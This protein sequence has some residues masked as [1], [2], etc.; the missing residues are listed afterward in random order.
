MHTDFIYV[1]T[2]IQQGICTESGDCAHIAGA[3]CDS[4]DKQCK[5]GAAYVTGNAGETSCV[6]NG[7]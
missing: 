4:T 3:Y 2:E 5:C 1:S 6:G 7:K